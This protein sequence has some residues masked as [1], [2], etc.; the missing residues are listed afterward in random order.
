MV[1]EVKEQILSKQLSL[2]FPQPG[3]TELLSLFPQ[4]HLDVGSRAEQSLEPGTDARYTT[5]Q[6]WEL[7]PTKSF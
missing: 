5:G 4:S 6:C 7:M 3:L 1:A 2:S